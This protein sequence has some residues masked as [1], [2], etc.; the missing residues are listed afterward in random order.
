M[1]KPQLIR[2]NTPFND[3]LR[4]VAINRKQEK[5]ARIAAKAAKRK[6]GKIA[7]VSRRHNR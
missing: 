5:D 3:K 4:N 1:S 7:R 2:S 6:R